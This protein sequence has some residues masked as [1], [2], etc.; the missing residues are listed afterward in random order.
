LRLRNAFNK[1]FEAKGVKG[2]VVASVTKSTT[3]NQNIVLTTTDAYTSDYLI[4]NQAIWETLVPFELAQKDTPWY[5]VVIHGVP[6]ADFNNS[7]GMTM[8]I[9]EIKTF[10]K[11]LNP[12]GTPYW[13]SSAEKRSTQRAGSVAVALPLK[14]K[15][16][17]LSVNG[18][19]SL[20]SVYES[21]SFIRL[22]LAHSAKSVKA[23]AT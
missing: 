3:D 8:I 13:L 9:D 23:T 19:I 12:I 6:T 15:R 17:K 7:D 14:K 11:G 18:F 22:Q 1:A 20:A 21:K 16:I 4:A 2:P 5:K 10:N